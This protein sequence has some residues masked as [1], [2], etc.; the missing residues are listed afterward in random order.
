VNIKKG[1]VGLELRLQ[2]ELE[3]RADQVIHEAPPLFWSLR[4]DLETVVKIQETVDELMACPA[5]ILHALVDNYRGTGLNLAP[6]P[7]LMS[8]EVLR[9]FPLNTWTSRKTMEHIQFLT[10]F[11]VSRLCRFPQQYLNAIHICCQRVLLECLD[12]SVS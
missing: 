12:R 4:S 7:R 1:E 3:L 2:G 10:M 8:L 9:Y 6:P 11:S 5:R